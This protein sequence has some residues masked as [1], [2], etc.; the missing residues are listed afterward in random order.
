M[1]FT[2][3][4]IETDKR[5]QVKK[6][7][8]ESW[9]A[10]YIISCGRKLYPADLPGFVALDNAGNLIGLVTYEIVGEQCEVVTLDA[11]IQW[12]GIGS[13]LLERTAEAASLAGCKRLW[14][15][16][17]NDNIEAIRFYQRRGMNLCDIHVNA[18]EH[19]RQLK[20]VIPRVGLHGIPLRD[21]VVFERWLQSD[22]IL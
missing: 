22:R 5:E 2:I 6:L 15:I 3:E 13:A 4:S 7:I 20:P 9:S 14:L 1:D 12:Q 18:L 11:L 10:E 17:T 19:S 21:E 16:T 8:T